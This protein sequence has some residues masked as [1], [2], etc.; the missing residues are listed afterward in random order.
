MF[1]KKMDVI[2]KSRNLLLNALDIDGEL[3]NSLQNQA[4]T[5]GFDA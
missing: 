3:I 5:T 2:K 1:A 4:F